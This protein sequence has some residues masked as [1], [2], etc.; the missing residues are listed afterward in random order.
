MFAK[1]KQKLNVEVANPTDVVGEKTV[2]VHGPGL[3]SPVSVDSQSRSSAD[4][5]CFVKTSELTVQMS[6]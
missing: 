3:A 1:L 4:Y 2:K 5:L 6:Y